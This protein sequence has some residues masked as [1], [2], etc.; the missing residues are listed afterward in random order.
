MLIGVGSEEPAPAAGAPTAA[1]S[2]T[3]VWGLARRH[4][5]VTRDRGEPASILDSTWGTARRR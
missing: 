5:F 1:A 4:R 3:G 2:G